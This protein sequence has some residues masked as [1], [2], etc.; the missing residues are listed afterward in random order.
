MR[1]G[2]PV[3]PSYAPRPPLAVRV[4][5][6]IQS[7]R[8]L[9]FWPCQLASWVGPRSIICWTLLFVVSGQV[10]WRETVVLNAE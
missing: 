1:V 4:S 6:P 3:V 7:V 5:V 9:S 10:T 2:R 8:R